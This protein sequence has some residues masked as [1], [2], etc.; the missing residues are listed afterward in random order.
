MYSYTWSGHPHHCPLDCGPMDSDSDSL[1]DLV[2]AA[3]EIIS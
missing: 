2:Q 1:I 3:E